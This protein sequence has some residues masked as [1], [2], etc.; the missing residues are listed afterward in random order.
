MPQCHNGRWEFEFHVCP[1][2][3]LHTAP[4]GDVPDTATVV[5]QLKQ[6][7][8][9]QTNPA[10]NTGPKLFRKSSSMPTGLPKGSDAQVQ[11]GGRTP[12]CQRICVDCQVPMNHVPALSEP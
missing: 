4:S 8:V 11:T 10:L 5:L 12:K 6:M 1:R 3:P 9:T 7:P 2:F